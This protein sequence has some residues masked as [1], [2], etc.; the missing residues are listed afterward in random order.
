MNITRTTVS[1]TVDD[2]AASS[3]FLAQHFGFQQQAVD[4]YEHYASLGREDVA[5][6]IIFLRR[7]IEVLPPSY[8]D[9]HA[10]GIILAFTVNDLASEERRLREAGVK[11]TLPLRE[12]PWGE[13]LFQVTDPNGIVVQ[14][15]E[16]ATPSQSA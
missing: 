16:W 14:L 4:E 9:Q 12:E 13:R 8:R 6:E 7:G 3:R 11:I 10:S 2:V 1:L 5:M 15:V